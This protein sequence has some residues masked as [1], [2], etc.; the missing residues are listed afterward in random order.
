MRPVC[1]LGTAAGAVPHLGAASCSR[2]LPTSTA[3]AD[4]VRGGAPTGGAPLASSSTSPGDGGAG[5]DMC[6]DSSA[7]CSAPCNALG[8][9]LAPS[10]GDESWALRLPCCCGP[11]LLAADE[12]RRDERDAAREEVVV[13]DAAAARGA[14]GGGGSGCPGN[15]RAGGGGGTR[16]AAAAPTAC[17][18]AGAGGANGAAAVRGAGGAGST[19]AAKLPSWLRSSV[20]TV[21]L[22][23]RSAAGW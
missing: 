12:I 7:S 23:R 20:V 1:E 21:V 4:A 16:A 5:G 15:A 19:P 18:G 22:A 2:A 10:A 9:S 14:A 6:R 13:R 11:E 3:L 8:A 17:T